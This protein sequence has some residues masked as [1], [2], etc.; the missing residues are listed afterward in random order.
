MDA[1]PA[2]LLDDLSSIDGVRGWLPLHTNPIGAEV[3]Y[4]D[5]TL[6][7]SLVS[8]RELADLPEARTPEGWLR[9]HPGLWPERGG[10]D[11]FFAARFVKQG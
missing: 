9:T 8:C 10:M 3:P 11:G 7:G 4:S 6:T 1:L 2:G 5:F